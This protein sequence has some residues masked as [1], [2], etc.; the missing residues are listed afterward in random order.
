MY[1][2]IQIA[3][4]A[5]LFVTM[6]FYSGCVDLPGK[7]VAPNWDVNLN[8]PITSKAYTLDDIIKEQKYISVVPTS[9]QQSIYLLHSDNYSQEINMAEY[10]KV[11]SPTSLTNQTIPVLGNNFDSTFVLYLPI[12]EG[13]E[14]DSA[15]FTNG[16][17]SFHFDNPAPFPVN[18]FISIPAIRKPDGSRFTDNIKLAPNSNNTQ[19]YSF[20]NDSYKITSSQIKAGKKDCVQ[21]LV[22]ANSAS[23]VNSY[24]TMDFYSSDFL[25]SYVSGYLPTKSLGSQSDSFDLNLGKVQDYRN[26][27]ILKDA[28][29][30]LFAQYIS[31]VNDPF[32]IEISNLNIT[33]VRNDGTTMS[34]TD[35]SGNKN[36]S[37]TLVNGSLNTSFD[38]SNSNITEFMSFLPDK[39]SISSDYVMNPDNI[40]TTGTATSSDSVKIETSFTTQS[41]LAINNAAITDTLDVNINQSDRDK[42]KNGKDFNLALDIQNGIPLSGN[43]QVVFADSLCRPLFT[44]NDSNGSS[45]FSID[46][47][48]V[49]QNGVMKTSAVSNKAVTLSTTQISM[50]SKAYYA[51]YTVTVATPNSGTASPTIVA[52]R[53]ED[54]IAVKASGSINYTVKPNDL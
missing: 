54:Q 41:Y 40:K 53:P 9:A 28:N 23:P 31:S 52:V 27:V 19:S 11:T 29:L 34:L 48:L 30:N 8:V 25:F 32:E 42:I 4:A 37:F 12:P 46:A 16:S 24:L 13:A 33:G 51:I 1:K 7:L 49:D 44:L 50:L 22:S 20:A 2:K 38:A 36:F 26:K 39:I 15:K 14:L 18:L 6:F 17:F 21:L 3:L 43:V 47:A 5:V 45:G 10:I 35:K